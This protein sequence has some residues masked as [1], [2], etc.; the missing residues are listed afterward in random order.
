MAKIE[1][2][3]EFTFEDMLKTFT[4]SGQF[5]IALP[6]ITFSP[7][8]KSYL[9]FILLPSCAKVTFEM[10]PLKKTRFTTQNNNFF[11][12]QYFIIY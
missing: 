12:T 8:I 1:K 6:Q 4:S 10:M 3:M 5:S 2:M 9:E 7:G 11:I